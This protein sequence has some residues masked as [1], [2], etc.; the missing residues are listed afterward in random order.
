MAGPRSANIKLILLIAAVIIV[1]ATLL[2][3]RILVNEL[4]ERERE[5]A[6][7][8]A[9]SIEFVANRPAEKSGEQSDYSFIFDE[10][11]RTIDFPVVLSDPGNSPLAPYYTSAKNV[12]FD[13]TLSPDQQR[14]YLAGVIRELDMVNQPIRVMLQDTVLVSYVHYGNS[15]LITRLR[16]LPY[17]E[18]AVAGMFIILGYVG[19]SYIKRNEQSNIWVG[20]SKETAHQ[21]GT[22]ISSLLG[23][24]EI[25]KG[26]EHDRSKLIPTIEEMERDIQRLQRVSDRFS[27]IGSRPSLREEDLDELIGSTI[28]YFKTRLPSRYG[29]GRQID[30]VIEESSHPKALVNRELFGWVIENLIRN[31]VDAFEEGKGKISFSLADRGAEVVID[32]RDTGKGIDKSLRRD[33]FRPGFSTKQR[34]WGL[35]LS[36]SKR[37]IESYHKGKIFVK[38]S[39][40]G[41]GTTFRIRLPK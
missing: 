25:I 38:E 37:I 35:G 9:K 11:I 1:V 20:M 27:K 12:Q 16:W 34:G 15:R 22:P 28:Q 33:I 19:F 39:R 8:Y 6:D 24:V 10:M 13:T 17:I 18:I 40:T 26:M 2:Y 4:L 32:V 31:A 30:I 41:K 29:E 14:E 21:L 23:W 7:I 3:T 36:L 5:V